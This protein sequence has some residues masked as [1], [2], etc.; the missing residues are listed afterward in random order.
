M[1][2]CVCEV[3]SFKVSF[4]LLWWTSEG[5]AQFSLSL[6]YLFKHQWWSLC[7]TFLSLTTL[8]RTLHLAFLGAKRVNE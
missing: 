3:S 7:P 4:F 8:M 5:F 2:C 6:K 1:W